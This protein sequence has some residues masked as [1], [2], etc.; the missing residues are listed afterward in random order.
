MHMNKQDT[1]LFQDTYKLATHIEQVKHTQPV[2]AKR[3]TTR[4]VRQRSKVQPRKT[5]VNVI[6]YIDTTQN[7]CNPV[8]TRIENAYRRVLLQLDDS[9]IST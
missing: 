8:A 6:Q 3:S 9:C 7:T 2:Q 4:N 5:Y 1:C